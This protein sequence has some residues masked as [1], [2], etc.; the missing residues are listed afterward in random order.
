MAHAS[1]YAAAHHEAASKIIG[2]GNFSAKYSAAGPKSSCSKPAN[3]DGL[4]LTDPVQ[5]G[6]VNGA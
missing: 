5:W 2:Q 1:Y 6:R 3:S 4:P